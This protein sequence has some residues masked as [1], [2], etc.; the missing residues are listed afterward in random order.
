MS[1]IELPLP[2]DNKHEK[3]KMQLVMST[4]NPWVT[5][6]LP[7]PVPAGTGKPPM[8]THINLF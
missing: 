6:V 8:G 1:V 7:V 3:K 5:F 4:G 2:L